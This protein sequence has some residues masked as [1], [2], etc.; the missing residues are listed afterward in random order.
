MSKNE[1][2]KTSAS[3]TRKVESKPKA[4]SKPK[5]ES[6][7]KK[8][9]SPE[10]MTGK[11]PYTPVGVKKRVLGRRVKIAIISSVAT[12]AVAGAAVGSVLLFSNKGIN[13]KY[14][15]NGKE[16]TMS[17]KKGTKIS[18]IAFPEAVP[19]YVFDGWYKDPG[20]TIRYSDDKVLE[21]DCELY[22]R[23]VPGEFRITYFSNDGKYNTNEKIAKGYHRGLVQSTNT[24][25]TL[26]TPKGR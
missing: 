1:K 16:E 25:Q 6:K 20:L 4:V 5:V 9:V 24:K 8:P 22:P 2:K 21:E 17:I 26:I 14:M 13:I 12:V 23:F 11:M 15:V 7:P 18:D 10:E 3:N 19:G